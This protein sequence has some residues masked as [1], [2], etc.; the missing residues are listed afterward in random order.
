VACRLAQF[1]TQ[2]L[3]K[4]SPW[5]YD[6]AQF[7]ELLYASGNRPV[8]DLIANLDGCTGGKAGEIVT[9]A[10]LDRGMCRDVT[11]AQATELLEAARA[12][13]RQVNPK[14]LGAVGP[15]AFP[16]C[17]YAIS[18]GVVSFGS[19][20]PMAEIP[21]V[22]EAW[23][24]RKTGSDTSLVACINRTPATGDLRAVRNKRHIYAFG[25]GLAHT[26]AK[27]PGGVQFD[28][29][30]NVTTPYMPITSYQTVRR[31]ICTPSLRKSK[32]P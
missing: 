1:G 8:P 10:N 6:A 11:A 32:P 14:R 30:L 15:Q 29:R 18:H 17:G 7:H 19:A 25:S 23:V 27:A 20:L 4:S 2:Y 9:S 3:G 12:N 5:W 22:V 24:E 13:A 28:I 26:I 31:Q 21:F 16:S